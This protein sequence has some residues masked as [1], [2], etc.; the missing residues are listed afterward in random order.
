[1]AKRKVEPKPKRKASKVDDEAKGRRR[2]AAKVS[3]ETLRRKAPVKRPK[4]DAAGRF[5]AK[6][7][8][9]K[10]KRKPAKA[11]VKAVV[12]PVQRKPAK[13][14]V[15]RKPVKA[16]VKAVVAPVKRK[17]AK[18]PVKRKPIPAPVKRKP[19]KVRRPTL[20]EQRAE[21]DREKRNRA[22]RNKRF[23][24]KAAAEF[25]RVKAEQAAIDAAWEAQIKRK[26]LRNKRRD[27]L[28]NPTATNILSTE[29]KLRFLDY[30]VSKV[31]RSEKLSRK[32]AEFLRGHRRRDDDVSIY[33]SGLRLQTKED[34]ASIWEKLN[35]SNNTDYFYEEVQE[36][37][38]AWGV[39]YGEVFVFYR[40]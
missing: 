39:T 30:L 40:S 21:L 19:A 25:L 2:I 34:K 9:E 28:D 38:T 14:P 16:P 3:Q 11:P 24:E 7:K 18:A 32:E 1:L 20:A 15:K 27:Q 6:A 13:A 5:V 10:V 22:R 29:E 23:E 33:Y 36:I 12:A 8:P 31:Q 17:P 35:E 37:A 4:R 26:Q